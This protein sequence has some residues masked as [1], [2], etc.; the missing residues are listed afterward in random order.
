M[1]S[2]IKFENNYVS[3]DFES[4]P[5]QQIKIIGTYDEPYFCGKDICT[6]LEYKDVKKALKQ[7][8]KPKHKKISKKL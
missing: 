5:G 3:F 7:H 8:V 4:K 2:L 1:Q 6:I